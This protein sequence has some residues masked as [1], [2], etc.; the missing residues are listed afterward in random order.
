MLLAIRH[1]YSTTRLIL[2]MFGKL[3]FVHPAILPYTDFKL[4]MKSDFF[5]SN[6]ENNAYLS[7]DL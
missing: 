3:S 1:L 4:S 5:L 7:V 2:V 6:K